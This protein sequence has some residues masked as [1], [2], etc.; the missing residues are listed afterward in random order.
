MLLNR[1][2]DFFARNTS[3]KALFIGHSRSYHLIIYAASEYSPGAVYEFNGANK[4]ME[5][6]EVL[7]TLKPQSIQVISTSP[8]YNL[9]P[10]E[11]VTGKD[12][13]SFLNELPGESEA[14]I[15]LRNEIP[16]M[17]LNLV[18]SVDS[19]DYE[20][21]HSLSN[22]RGI[23]HLSA[24]MISNLPHKDFSAIWS[25]IVMYIYNGHLFVLAQRH[26]DLVL[27][28]TFQYDTAEDVLYYI[29]WLKQELFE[30]FDELPVFVNGFVAPESKLAS[31]LKEFIHPLYFGTSMKKKALSADEPYPDYV[32]EAL[33]RH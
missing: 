31:K 28:N 12:D 22:N 14:E 23:A 19:G 9:V 7:D 26:S 30:D 24:E 5:L 8:E 16:E 3:Y 4:E 17:G 6:L 11:L 15:V 33:L 18:F 32:L 27:S 13:R 25:K 21:L 2:D 1:S 10:L 20:F 29:L